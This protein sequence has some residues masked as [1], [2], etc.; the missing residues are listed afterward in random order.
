MLLK[1]TDGTLIDISDVLGHEF[2]ARGQA[3]RAQRTTAQFPGPAVAEVQD[4]ETYFEQ[5]PANVTDV[6][7]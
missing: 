6:A 3:V 4:P 2:I 1:A 5:V 7:P